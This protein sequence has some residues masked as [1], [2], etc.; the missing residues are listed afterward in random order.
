VVT[1]IL[2]IIT[3]GVGAVANIA[4][5]STRLVKVAKLL[6]KIAAVLK[7]TSPDIKILDR[8]KGDIK[9]AKSAMKTQTTTNKGVPKVKQP[10]PTERVDNKKKK[11]YGEN[12]VEVG[13]KTETD[14]I[15][16]KLNGEIYGQKRLNS[17]EKY[18]NRR[19]AELRIDDP[20]LPSR[21]R[22]A[23]NG[24]DN[25]MYLRSDATE[26]E[27][28]HELSHYLHCKKIGKKEYMRLKRPT[29]P[30]QYVYDQLRGSDRRWKLL[31]PNERDHA[32]WYVEASGGVAW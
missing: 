1:V 18:L 22:G 19:G 26:Y 32:M 14:S 9:K 16:G 25:V 7:K 29:G 2:A 4:A 5:K 12:D 3:A 28:W 10:K 27:V 20:K 11:E 6:K 31:T 30:E 23:Y 15:K 8:G 13:P 17:L 21:M 24:R